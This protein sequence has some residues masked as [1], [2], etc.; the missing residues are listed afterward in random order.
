MCWKVEAHDRSDDATSLVEN[1][2]LPRSET[3]AR[4]PAVC[5]CLCMSDGRPSRRER[6]QTEAA[7]HDYVYTTVCTHSDRGGEGHE[8]CF[9]ERSVAVG[10]AVP[11]DRDRRVERIESISYSCVKI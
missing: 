5:L 8:D 9:S 11:C 7:M 2:C 4:F 3:R 6:C 1:S 10:A